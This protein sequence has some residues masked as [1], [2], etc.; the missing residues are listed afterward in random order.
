MKTIAVWCRNICVL[1]WYLK[2]LS[3]SFF[4]SND[5]TNTSILL[6]HG[7]MTHAETMIPVEVKSGS[8]CKYKRTQ[9][10]RDRKMM[11]FSVMPLTVKIEIALE[12]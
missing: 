8:A 5:F 10:S 11:M 7:N 2:I 4:D 1:Q 9:S 6:W 12:S 3:K